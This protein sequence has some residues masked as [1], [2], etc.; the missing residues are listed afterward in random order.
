MTFFELLRNCENLIAKQERQK[1]A[2][3][4][5]KQSTLTENVPQREKKLPP[6]PQK[7]IIESFS[8]QHFSIVKN[9]LVGVNQSFERF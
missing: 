3:V 2:K 6:I 1:T 8:E 7:I 4:L 5:P 9:F